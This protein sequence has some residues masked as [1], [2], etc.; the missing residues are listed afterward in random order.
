MRDW[1]TDLAVDLT[2][3]LLAIAGAIWLVSATAHAQSLYAEP[4]LQAGAPWEVVGASGPC[5]CTRYPATG[6]YD[7]GALPYIGGAIGLNPQSTY[8]LG[9]AVFHW[10]TDPDGAHQVGPQG[11]TL[12]S[13]IPS[14]AQLRLPNQAPYLYLTVTPLVGLNELHANLYLTGVPSPVPELPADTMLV[15]ER[16]TLAANTSVGVWS[17]DYFAGEALWLLQAPVGVYVTIYN[18]DLEGHFYPTDAMPAGPSRMTTLP[19]GAWLIVVSNPT[20]NEV[21][22]VATVTPLLTPSLRRVQ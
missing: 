13:G 7:V 19:M 20:P 18:V 10:T 15:T 9:V 14:L 22:Y 5:G 16:H 8:S 3:G 12:A 1:L 11:I 21:S 17:A 6:T 4:F 2:L